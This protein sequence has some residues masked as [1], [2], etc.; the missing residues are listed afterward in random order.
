MTSVQNHL[1][2]LSGNSKRIGILILLGLSLQ[3]CSVFEGIFGRKNPP[4]PPPPIEEDI[5]P[6]PEPEVPEVVVV[7]PK[8]T[9]RIPDE[10]IIIEKEKINIAVM[11]PF[12]LDK[13]DAGSSLPSAAQNSL[14]VYKGIKFAIDEVNFTDKEVNI[15]FIDND[16][17]PTKTES[18]VGQSPFPA[19]DLVIGPLYSKSIQAIDG[20]SKAQQI[21]FISPLSSAENLAVDNKFIYAA[22]ATKPSRYKQLLEF[23]SKEFINP[24]L[25]VY[26]QSIKSEETDKNLLINT[27]TDM[28][29][30]IHEELS[31]GR[32]T[33]TAVNKLLKEGQE[34]VLIFTV[35]SNEEGIR[36]F[37]QMLTY[38][39]GLTS[40]YDINVIGLS[41]WNDVPKFSAKKYPELDV[42]V[43]DRYL[44]KTNSPK[45]FK[46]DSLKA[47]NKNQPLHIYSLQGYDIMSYMF[48]LIEKHGKDFEKHLID[49]EYQGVQNLFSFGAYT[50]NG[51]FRFYDN[52]H[53][54]ILKFNGEE[55]KLVD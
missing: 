19:V 51:Q 10:P 6:E 48:M 25:G 22:N 27:A 20:F 49:H 41:E 53:I 17:N 38:L 8:D 47:K 23:V 46:F 14:E 1:Q 39:N 54:N 52:K 44:D 15:Y 40:K 12:Q 13:M 24:N 3:S 34:N 26:Y 42:Y 2:L 9:I 11:L 31:E 4:P 45:A 50:E 5:E 35:D 30:E 43:L 16:G 29:I 36:Y 28:N 37:D 55:W 18:L 7:E 33:L 21:P 32:N